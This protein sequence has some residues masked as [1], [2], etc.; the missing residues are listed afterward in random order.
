MIDFVRDGL[1]TESINLP[2]L[3]PTT[4]H[5]MCIPSPIPLRVC[6]T[7]PEAISTDASNLNAHYTN[8]QA[9]NSKGYKMTSYLSV[10]TL[11]SKQAIGYTIC[12]LS[13]FE[14]FYK[15]LDIGAAHSLAKNVQPEDA[16]S[17]SHE[18]PWLLI[19]GKASL[20]TLR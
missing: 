3:H 15:R 8:A 2:L 14:F 5:A 12:P 18:M 6:I 16:I 7:S 9:Q 10:V 19:T 4:P 13:L 11:V 20:I 1:F 17:W